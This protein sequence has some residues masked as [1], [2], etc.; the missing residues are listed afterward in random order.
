MTCTCVYCTCIY[1]LNAPKRKSLLKHVTCIFI[2]CSKYRNV[3]DFTCVFNIVVFIY[4][5]QEDYT[6]LELRRVINWYSVFTCTYFNMTMWYKQT[7]SH[8]QTYTHS[9]IHVHVQT[10]THSHIQ[11][12]HYTDRHRHKPPYT[13]TDTHL[14]SFAASLRAWRAQSTAFLY[15]LMIVCGWILASI[16]CSASYTIIHIHVLI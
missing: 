8:I 14:L 5:V 2:Q 3:W 7:H 16:N 15:P 11:T 6:N 10:Y 9:H 4:L 13:E 1:S 12:P